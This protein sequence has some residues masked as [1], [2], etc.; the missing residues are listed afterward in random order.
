[1]SRGLRAYAAT[2]FGARAATET[3]GPGLILVVAASGASIARGPWLLATLTGCAAISGPLMG[4]LLDRT[5]RP[6]RVFA[7]NMLLLA[8]A[9]SVLALLVPHQPELPLWPLLVVA[10]VGGVAEPPLT[11][12]WSAQLPLFIPPHRLSRAFA[13]DIGTYNLGGIVGPVLAASALLLGTSAPLLVPAALLVGALAVLPSVPIPPRETDRVHPP[14]LAD[15]RLGVGTLFRRPALRRVTIVS[16]LGL[17]GQ[18]ALIVAAP[19]LSVH[20]TGGLTFVG[21]L[22]GTFAAG[23]LIATLLLVRFPMRRPP[24]GLVVVAVVFGAAAQLLLAGA[25]NR[26]VALVG[27]LGMGLADGPMA[28]GMLSVREREAPPAARAQVFTTGASLRTSAYALATAAL[29]TLAGQGFRTVL[30]L[31]AAVEVVGVLAG[32]LAGLDRSS[33][34]HVSDVTPA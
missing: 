2:A 26:W 27:A 34:D 15:L 23:G 21:L 18:A 31:G 16:T 5:R 4:L 14:L 12:A 3:V 1:M 33:T 25:P 11:G 10:A 20:M 7:A 32:L 6:A 29:G 19:S 28:T 13:I 8:V 17:A 24:D 22:L 9:L 30:L